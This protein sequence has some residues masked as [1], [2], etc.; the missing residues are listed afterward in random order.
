MES[1]MQNL[2]GKLRSL[3]GTR[4]WDYCVLWKLS[5]DQRFV[6]WLGCCCGGAEEIISNL[7]C[8]NNGGEGFC[9]SGD[10]PSSCRDVM[11]HH[12]RTKSCE[13][14]ANLPV[15]IPLESGIHA[16]TLVSNQTAWL[17]FL[18]RSE[19]EFR[20][21]ITCTRVLIPVPG[22]LV[23][24]FVT[25]QV[26]EDQHVVDFVM[27]ECNFLLDHTSTGAL[28]MNMMGAEEVESKPYEIS[29]GFDHKGAKED[30]NLSYDQQIRLNFLPQLGEYEAEHIKMKNDYHGL[31]FLPE[32]K[33]MDMNPFN[34]VVAEDEIAGMEALHNSMEAGAMD[35][36]NVEGCDPS[37]LVKEQHDKETFSHENGRL[38]SGSDCSDQMDDDDDAKFK[39]KTGKGSQA[40]NLMA[41]RRRRKKLNDRL[42]AL[43]SL[44]P[45]ISKLDRASI[46]GDAINYVKE[47][48][49]E[50]KELQE[51]LEENLDTD[52]GSNRHNGNAAIGG[53]NDLVKG[54]H[55]GLSCNTT[56]VPNLKQDMDHDQ[57]S[58]EKGQEME[59]QVD[60]AQVDG[61]EFFVKVICEYKPGGFTKLM[62]AM[63][64]LG[65]EVT[66]A[67]TTRFLGLVSN[68]FKVERKDSEMVQ[69]EHVRDSLLE[70][71]RNTSR[72]WHG[73]GDDDDQMGNVDKNGVE[74]HQN[75]DNHHGHG[76]GVHHHL[77]D[78]Q[79]NQDMSSP[80]HHHHLLH[81]HHIHHYHNQV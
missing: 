32:N 51:E 75:Y 40:K 62:E 49:N 33:Q 56:N 37:L 78:H 25:R 17:N 59:P 46:L 1:T 28:S 18:D 30:M 34:S 20:Q 50:A 81:H 41:E 52:D 38:D 24:L 54:F 29:G 15:S 72:G 13:L 10:V 53:N 26:S 39:K 45:K 57:S 31:G 48:Q 55:S 71:T 69:A 8:N 77:H 14:L 58:N 43:R 27:G 35:M 63:D 66:N 2:L 3:V 9:F 21:E 76:H 6:K 16:E 44:V 65:L 23:E 60:V 4:G 73:G 64:S 74:Y 42:Y 61:K 12:P 36:H 7:D 19:P 47:L 22:G 5:D 67:N 79:I 70:I 68:V 80:H 11:F